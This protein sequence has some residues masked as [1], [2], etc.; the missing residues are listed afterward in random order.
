MGRAE[1]C[2]RNLLALS[3][4]RCVF[5]GGTLSAVGLVVVLSAPVASAAP[6][7]FKAVLGPEAPGATGSGDVTVVLDT[8]AHTLAI[9]AQWSGLSGPTTVAHI[10][11][12][13]ATPETGTVAVAVTPGTLP[14]FPVG[15]T[16]GSYSIQLP[17]TLSLGIYTSG[18]VNNFGGGTAG[19]AEAALLAGMQAGRAYFNI[20]TSAFPGG[21]IRGFLAP[22]PEPGTLALFGAGLALLG[23]RRRRR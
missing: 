13:T 9:D 2:V 17:D 3:A 20:H 23:L 10:H 11:C 8:A 1:V 5:Y 7:T 12:C 22:V 6:I 16:S 21:E 4:K 19:G 14:G 18:F 15:A